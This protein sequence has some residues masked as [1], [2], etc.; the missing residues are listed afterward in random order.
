[1]TCFLSAVYDAFS[2]FVEYI[3]IVLSKKKKNSIVDAKAC[4]YG[5][6]NWLLGLKQLLASSDFHMFG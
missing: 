4:S 3:F 6:F 5:V 1:M 2:L